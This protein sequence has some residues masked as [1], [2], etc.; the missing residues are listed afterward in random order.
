MMKR[1]T[2]WNESAEWYAEHLRGADTY[3]AKVI[4]PNLL[5][6]MDVK[7]GEAILDVGCGDGFF[8][9]EFFGKT[10]SAVGV[11]LS[12]ELILRAKAESP[13]EI[14]YHVSSGHAMPFLQAGTFSKAVM[15]HALQNIE[16]VH[17]TLAEC[18]RVLRPQGSLFVVVNHPAFR[19]PKA[20]SWGW[21]VEEKKQYRRIDHYLSESKVKI[22]M[23]PGDAPEEYTISFH[24]PL[25]YYFKAF[26][27]A[28]F[29]VARLEEWISHRKSQK[30][31]RAE[32]EDVARKEI[33]LFM[34]LE[35]V[36]NR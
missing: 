35:A 27:K 21:D 15:V 5:R 32:A 25:Q 31:P 1:D 36:K 28:G 3:Q 10:G 20:S 13:K 24:R 8:T 26:L 7:S 23:H 2:A 33:P 11:D 16:D 30:G 34:C 18:A 9:R 19:V 17:G 14:Q 6:L 29:A 22:Q 12:R 4:L